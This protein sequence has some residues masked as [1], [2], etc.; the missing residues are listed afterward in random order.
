MNDKPSET[1]IDFP[2]KHKS[3]G[4]DSANTLSEADKVQKKIEAYEKA[5]KIGRSKPQ[6]LGNPSL[7]SDE[8]TLH[9]FAAALKDK[10]DDLINQLSER[11]SSESEMIYDLTEIKS[12]DNDLAKIG[13]ALRIP[14]QNLLK[15]MIGIDPEKVSPPV[16]LHWAGKGRRLEARWMEGGKMQYAPIPKFL[17][18][19][20][21]YAPNP[22]REK[23]IQ[24]AKS[25]LEIKEVTEEETK[26]SFTDREEERRKH[27]R[28][29]K[30]GL[31]LGEEE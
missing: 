13:Q 14:V 16:G 28:T 20:Y 19:T 25:T 5:K 1:I 10:I 22:K 23:K 6:E 24:V 8:N 9:P 21:P 3:S 18:P 11:L 29:K 31:G 2:N 15:T 17:W 26:S 27:R 7:S 12:L 4:K 30:K